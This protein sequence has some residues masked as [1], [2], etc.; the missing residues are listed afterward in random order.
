M[1]ETALIHPADIAPWN[2][3]TDADKV[4]GLVASMEA[5][6]WTGAPIVLDGEQA[7]TG[8]HR[9]AAARTADVEIPTVDIRALFATAGLDY[10]DT[11]AEY[12]DRYEVIIRVE[13]FLPTRVI[14]E[15]GFDAH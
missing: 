13:E 4:A 12:G 9:I 3:V 5:D 7:L 15:Y 2:D 10:D 8:S 14:D 6:G 11:V 1:T